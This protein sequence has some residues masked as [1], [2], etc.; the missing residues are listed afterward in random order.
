[1]PESVDMQIGIPIGTPGLRREDGDD[2]E[3]NDKVASL[4]NT[5]GTL[6]NKT[7][8]QDSDKP[9]NFSVEKFDS[10]MQENSESDGGKGWTLTKSK[11]NKLLKEPKED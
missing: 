2:S 10:F 8:D 3:D 6:K 11:L 4:E 7:S 5:I 9:F 1:M